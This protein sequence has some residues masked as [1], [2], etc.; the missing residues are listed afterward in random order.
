MD[1]PLGSAGVAPGRRSVLEGLQAYR[2]A[3]DLPVVRVLADPDVTSLVAVAEAAALFDRDV[4][5]DSARPSGVQPTD[6]A[7][8]E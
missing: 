8:D 1:V 5:V 6:P 7:P 2:S 4:D 3:V